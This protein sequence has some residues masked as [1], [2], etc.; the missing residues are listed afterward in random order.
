MLPGRVANNEMADIVRAMGRRIVERDYKEWSA[1]EI[2]AVKK[3]KVLLFEAA[4]LGNHKFVME[5]LKLYPDFT[6]IRNGDMHTIFHVAV[7]NRQ[8]NVY[9]LLFELG[10]KKLGMA[11]PDGNN[12]LH[13]A[14]M[15]PAE[16]R[17]NIVSGAALQMQRELLWFKVHI[18]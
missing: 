1:Y 18:S 4:G 11:D 8:Q 16:G 3:T 5:L 2:V 17:L 13:L 9:N 6:W 12:I 15:K 7:K 14:A 10:S